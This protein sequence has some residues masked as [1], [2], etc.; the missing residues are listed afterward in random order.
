MYECG[1]GHSKSLGREGDMQGVREGRGVNIQG[2]GE[3]GIAFKGG[4]EG[5]IHRGGDIQREEGGS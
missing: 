2:R 4:G 5:V 3:R 1:G